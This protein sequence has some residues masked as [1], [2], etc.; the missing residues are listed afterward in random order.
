MD[1]KDICFC[2]LTDEG[3]MLAITHIDGLFL[4]YDIHSAQIIVSQ[5]AH[6][7]KI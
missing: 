4:V 7:K 2:L 5:I 6:T 1:P 3:N